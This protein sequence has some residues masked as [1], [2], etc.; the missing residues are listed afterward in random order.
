MI[1]V[2]AAINDVKFKDLNTMFSQ[3]GQLSLK[4]DQQRVPV[5]TVSHSENNNGSDLLR[6]YYVAST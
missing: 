6:I 3:I 4:C 1:L 2:A 5:D